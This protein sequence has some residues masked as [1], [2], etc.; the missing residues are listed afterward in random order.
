MA[1]KLSGRV[2]SGNGRDSRTAPR[3]ARFL[4][5]T[6]ASIDK[7]SHPRNAVAPGV[8]PALELA[9]RAVRLRAGARARLTGDLP[10]RTRLHLS[11]RHAHP[12]LASRPSSGCHPAD[13]RGNG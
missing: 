8:L 1:R 5:A 7:V 4:D 12:A 11:E 3:P 10:Q 6:K 9:E 2:K 13:G